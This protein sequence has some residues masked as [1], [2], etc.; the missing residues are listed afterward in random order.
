VAGTHA[1]CST[2]LLTA[3]FVY[4][5]IRFN[6][7]NRPFLEI[8]VKLNQNTDITMDYTG[9]YLDD[10]IEGGVYMALNIIVLGVV[11]VGV[12]LR[13]VYAFIVFFTFISSLYA[14]SWIREKIFRHTVVRLPIRPPSFPLYEFEPSSSIKL[15]DY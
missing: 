8:T 9:D 4:R 1:G 3:F 6:F 13:P 12:V 7:L 5:V 2:T 14:W 15:Q 10:D 11:A